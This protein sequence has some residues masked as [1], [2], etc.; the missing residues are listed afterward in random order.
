MNRN[1]LLVHIGVPKSATTSLQFGAFPNHPDIRY[2]G[3]PYYDEDFGYDGSLAT[4]ELI[5]SLWKQD[6]LEFDP[7]LARR[8]FDS[9]ILPRLSGNRLGVLSE[10]GLSHAAASDRSLT[11]RRL[12]KLCEGIRCSILITVREQKQALF[13]RH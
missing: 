11:A 3:K 7:G 10:E 8:R 13:S 4:A 5:D 9:G 2:L 1:R 12:A 6:D